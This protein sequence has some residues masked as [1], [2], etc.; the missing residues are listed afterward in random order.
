MSEGL[1]LSVI[2]KNEGCV[3]LVFIEDSLDP[4]KLLEK[5]DESLN[6]EYRKRNDVAKW[7]F[8]SDDHNPVPGD[9]IA[10][11]T[12]DMD[13]WLLGQAATAFGWGS[14]VTSHA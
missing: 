5:I 11:R 7:C 4:Q 9:F 10:C 6:N 1:C 3:I 8:H 12:C 14:E 13:E 2:T